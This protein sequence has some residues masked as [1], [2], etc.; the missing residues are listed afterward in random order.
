MATSARRALHHP[1]SAGVFAAMAPLCGWAYLYRA[2]GEEIWHPVPECPLLREPTQAQQFSLTDLPVDSMVCPACGS[3][4]ALPHGKVWLVVGEFLGLEAAFADWRHVA[5]VRRRILDPF[6]DLPHRTNYPAAFWERFREA[7]EPI[8][9]N[10]E[11][12]TAAASE[13]LDVDELLA[14]IV[15]HHLSG[16]TDSPASKWLRSSLV[17]HATFRVP[18]IAEEIVAGMLRAPRRET[19]IVIGEREVLALGETSQQLL[20]LLVAGSGDGW[21]VLDL[22]AAVA[23]A[24]AQT[25]G[26]RMLALEAEEDRDPDLLWWT[27]KLCHASPQRTLA[28]AHAAARRLVAASSARNSDA[29]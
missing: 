10:L 27:V 26:V 29:G 8:I 6:K 4:K 23:V 15:V 25:P 21:L 1:L 13:R 9:R 11:Q 24:L 12:R 19:L 18:E 16:G 22:P 14:A 17:R 3:W 7:L 20:D 2:R 5:R 28:E